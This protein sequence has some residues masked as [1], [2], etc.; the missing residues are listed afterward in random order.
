[1]VNKLKEQFL[2]LDYEVQ[3][4]KKLQNLKQR[5]MDV[6]TYTEEFHKL[7]MRFFNAENEKEKVARYLNGLR[8]NIQD[9]LSLVTPKTMEEFFQVASKKEEKLKRKQE[10][11][12]RGRGNFKGRGSFGAR[13]K[14]QK[15]QDEYS[16]HNEK[17]GEKRNRGGFRGR[18]PNVR[19]RFNG[20]GRGSNTFFG[21]CYNC[22]QFGHLAFNCPEKHA[23][24][25]HG[26]ETRN[27][28]V[29]E[30]DAQSVN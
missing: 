16:G 12:G 28:L 9:E 6:A 24:R 21:R 29:Q 14:Y 22:N 27:Q 8:F 7:S 3:V 11:Q 5:D 19:G 15:Q 13:G 26:G 1:M 20:S 18:R 25:S 4:F 30:E 23:S 2:L 10:H 17:G